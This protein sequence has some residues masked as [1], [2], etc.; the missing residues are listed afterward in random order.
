MERRDSALLKAI[1]RGFFCLAILLLLSRSHLPPV[2]YLHSWNQVSTLAAIRALTEPGG[3]VLNPKDVASRITWPGAEVHSPSW[4]PDR[5]FT[6]FEEFP[7]YHLMAAEFS[8]IGFRI[9]LAGHLISILF[10]ILAALGIMRLTRRDYYSEAG[11][12]SLLLASIS[13]MLLYYGQAIMSDM[14][15]TASL[16]WAIHFLQRWRDTG[17]NSSFAC[18]TLLMV[19]ASLFKSYAAVFVIPCLSIIAFSKRAPGGERI[20]RSLLF[21]SLALL[22]VLSWH[23]FV[24]LSSSGHDETLSHSLEAKLSVLLSLSFL[25]VLIED[26][27]RLL[28]H[29]PGVLFILFGLHGV[30]RRKELPPLSDYR[31]WYLAA[32]VLFLMATADKLPNHDYYFL[33]G[34]P[35][36]VPAASASLIYGFQGLSLFFK[37][38]TVLTSA[39]VILL[40][41]IGVSLKKFWKATTINPDVMLCAKAVREVLPSERLLVIASDLSRYNSIHFYSGRRGF[42]LEGTDFPLPRY[43]DAGAGVLAVNLPPEIAE[44]LSNWALDQGA[45]P[46]VTK[47]PPLQDFKG[48]ER[49]C[50]LFEIRSGE[51]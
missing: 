39:A 19:F 47:L 27:F 46:L 33:L 34:A 10:F 50:R 44:E 32:F 8:K 14:A 21:P 2:G 43:T 13:F 25:E 48:R 17:Q 11:E 26:L 30:V 7:L 5:R 38:S 9:E 4:I 23:V 18:G 20:V 22:P 49:V 45:V 3:S 16:I 37:R 24:F 36:L 41:T 42:P 6:I 51:D 29:G 1:A 40:V 12:L 15:M 35:L 28:G 31:W